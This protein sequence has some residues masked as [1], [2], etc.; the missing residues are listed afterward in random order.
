MRSSEA[1]DAAGRLNAELV[2]SRQR[3]VAARESLQEYKASHQVFLYDSYYSSKLREMSDLTI[4]L[5]RFDES[6]VGRLTEG[7]A[8]EQKRAILVQSLDELRRQIAQLPAIERELQLRQSDVDVANAA[9][10][11]VAKQLKDLEIKSDSIPD[12]RLISEAFVSELPTSPRREIYLGAALLAGLLFG[13][14][15]AFL[16]EYMNG[17]VR[18][19]ADIEEFVGLKVIA[20]IPRM[21]R[22]QFPQEVG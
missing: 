12:A 17:K 19:I 7:G 2:Q 4:E 6:S 20:T 9:Y 11:T 15:I 10:A 16:L 8:H 14:I 21:R 18:G 5:T 22:P 13:V 3:L 1:K